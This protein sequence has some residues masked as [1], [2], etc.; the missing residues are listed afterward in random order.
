MHL[1]TLNPITYRTSVI[2]SCTLFTQFQEPILL[3]CWIR[4]IIEHIRL[5]FF[6]LDATLGTYD[7]FSSIFYW[8]SRLFYRYSWCLF[9]KRVLTCQ[10]L[11]NDKLLNNC[12]RICLGFW[13]LFSFL[14]GG[15]TLWN[16]SKGNIFWGARWPIWFFILLTVWLFWTL[17]SIF[18]SL[19][20]VNVYFAWSSIIISD[21][22]TSAWEETEL[23]CSFWIN[24]FWL[25]RVMWG[26][27]LYWYICGFEFRLL[28]LN[29]FAF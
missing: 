6:M 1:I 4:V 20:R 21:T 26:V 16:W 5:S 29:C 7:L 18:S 19:W 14:H 11:L 22:G 13:R 28:G 9:H 8:S 10:L 24:S 2:I 12:W 15:L 3:N 27:L 23:F 17:I 25:R